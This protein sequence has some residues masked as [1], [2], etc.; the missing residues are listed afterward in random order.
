MNRLISFEFF[1]HRREL[2]LAESYFR[3]VSG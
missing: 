2:L 3:Q 1:G